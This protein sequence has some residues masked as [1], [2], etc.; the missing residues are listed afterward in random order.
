MLIFQLYTTHQA[1]IPNVT[2]PNRRGVGTQWMGYPRSARNNAT[3]KSSASWARDSW[4]DVPFAALLPWSSAQTH[5]PAY[6]Y[7]L[8]EDSLLYV[9]K[10]IKC[11]MSLLCRK[12]YL[13]SSIIGSNVDTCLGTFLRTI[14]SFTWDLSSAFSFSISSIWFLSC[15]FWSS[16]FSTFCL[17]F[18]F[19]YRTASLGLIDPITDRTGWACAWRNPR[20]LRTCKQGLII[21]HIKQL[22]WDD[23]SEGLQRND[24]CL[25]ISRVLT[26]S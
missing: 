4:E 21:E 9:L 13:S 11:T 17:S 26:R 3:I 15:W 7:K 19:F 8:N 5:S 24:R 23:S 6:E 16:E 20:G 22:F 10:S 2:H 1:Q 14:F 25:S 18:L 12:A